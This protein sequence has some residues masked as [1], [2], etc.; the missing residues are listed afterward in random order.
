MFKYLLIQ[1]CVRTEARVSKR[2]T[3][4]YLIIWFSRVCEVLLGSDMG[5]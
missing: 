2:F 1:D 3:Q 4:G 5:R